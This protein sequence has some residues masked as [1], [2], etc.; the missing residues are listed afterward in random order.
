M[1]NAPVRTSLALPVLALLLALLA[2]CSAPA[3]EIAAPAASTTD[4]SSMDHSSMGGA[5]PFDAAFIDSM[6]AHHNGAVAM[7]QALLE[8][9]ERP[10]LLA[11]ADAV[12]T[13]QSAEIEQMQGWRAAWYP[14]EPASAGVDME[15][16]AMAVADDAS[17]PYDKRFLE[18]MIDHHNGAIAMAEHALE[19]AEHPELA[20]LA[21][22]IIAA[23][24]AEVV[25]MEQWL[26]EWYPE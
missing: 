17:T 13:T 25:Q 20:T 4:H 14:D 15:M 21:A 23:Q 8:N 1:L 9:T 3:A 2:A 10:E 7:A 12:I 19:G 6:V 16:G 22:A 18:A 11:M 24:Q 5:T 26:Q